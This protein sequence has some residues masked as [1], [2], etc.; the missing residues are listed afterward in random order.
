MINN[1]LLMEEGITWKLFTDN[2]EEEE[3]F[4]FKDGDEGDELVSIFVKDVVFEDKLKFFTAPKL[5]CY[6]A[7]PMVI[8]TCLTDSGCIDGGKET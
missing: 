1:Q 3:D 7:I 6:Y 2:S 5:G 4:I 8:N